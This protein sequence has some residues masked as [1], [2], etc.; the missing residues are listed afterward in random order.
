MKKNITACA[1]LLGGLAMLGATSLAAAE[2]TESTPRKPERNMRF[3]R[4]GGQR[5]P[6]LQTASLVRKELKEYQA[7]PTPEKFAALEKALNEA[8]KKDTAERKAKL[9]KELAELEKT[10]NERAAEL[11]KKVKA[12]DFKFPSA[13]A[14]RKGDM[15]GGFR[16]G[17]GRPPR[18]NFKER[19][20]K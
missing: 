5:N 12:G 4:F 15:R 17:A 3:E 1:L 9:E 8:V 10:Q 18:G 20:E 19:P 11:L 6:L 13:D 16:G 14:M 2:K 7:N